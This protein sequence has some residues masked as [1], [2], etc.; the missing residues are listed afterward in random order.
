MKRSGANSLGGDD[1]L[2][3]MDKVQLY[4]YIA[5]AVGV[6]ALITG[7]LPQDKMDKVRAFMHKNFGK[8][9]QKDDTR[10]SPRTQLIFFGAFFLFI[11]L[12]VSGLIHL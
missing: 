7:L 3:R 8:E 9:G 1:I 5:C 2:P 11:G 6:A 10:V 12:V 4:G